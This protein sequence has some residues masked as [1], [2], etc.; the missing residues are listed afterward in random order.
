MI[1]LPIETDY[2]FRIMQTL[3]RENVRCDTTTLAEKCGITK[4][5]ALKVLRRLLCG[6]LVKA[7]QG[8]NGG[9][10]LALPAGQITL[11]SIM[12]AV[13]EDMKFS[14]CLDP[15][16]DCSRMHCHKEACCFHRLFCE[17]NEDIIAKLSSMRLSDTV[18]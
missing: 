11:I 7:F 15:E 2:A 1:K 3:A 9:Y 10:E 18:K 14:R 8:V 16:Y 13:G 6:G 12:E 17:I 5:S 4:Q